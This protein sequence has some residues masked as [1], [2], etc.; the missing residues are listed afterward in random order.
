[1]KSEDWQERLADSE[2]SQDELRRA[3]DTAR[4]EFEKAKRAYDEAREHFRDVGRIPATDGTLA[5]RH[6]LERYNTSLSRYGSA[7]RD[8]SDAILKQ[9]EQRKH[10]G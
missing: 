7:L 2:Q 9:S 10:S 3:L 1:M 4:I 8:F 6:A 5:L